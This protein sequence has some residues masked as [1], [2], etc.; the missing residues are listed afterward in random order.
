[1]LHR[2]PYLWF[3]LILVTI[4]SFA[5]VELST[6][7]WVAAIVMGIAALKGYLIID[8]FME[9]AGHRH[10]L[11]YAMNLYCPVLALSIWALLTF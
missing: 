10:I 6:L 2:V 11:R 1:M 3:I 7:P 4:V 8:G 9:L 5:L